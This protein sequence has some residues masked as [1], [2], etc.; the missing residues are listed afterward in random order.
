MT[1]LNG[2]GAVVFFFKKIVYYSVKSL[3][4]CRGV[5][6]ACG[7]IILAFSLSVVAFVN[8]MSVV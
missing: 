1:H 4:C 7:A 3:S 6:C 5:S 2:T 8:Y